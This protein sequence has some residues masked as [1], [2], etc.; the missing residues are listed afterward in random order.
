MVI[1]IL[2][3]CIWVRSNTESC[4]IFK[5]K[6]NGDF[7]KNDFWKH[8][9]RAKWDRRCQHN[10]YLDIEVM[11]CHSSLVLPSSSSA[12]C[13]AWELSLGRNHGTFFG[14]KLLRGFLRCWGISGAYL[15][16]TRW[17]SPLLSITTITTYLP[18]FFSYTYIVQEFNGCRFCVFKV[19]NR[20]SLFTDLEVTSQL[21]EATNKSNPFSL[22]LLWINQ[23]FDC[24]FVKFMSFICC[25]SKWSYLGISCNFV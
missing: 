5:K 22:E 15:R 16:I 4:R 18:C 6:I 11:T 1:T 24:T 20:H 25:C 17:P 14:F 9:F 12:T 10:F 23:F 7:W 8:F 3:I 13:S 19:L 21:F 2:H